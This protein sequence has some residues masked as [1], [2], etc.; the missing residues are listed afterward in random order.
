MRGPICILLAAI[1]VLAAGCGGGDDS[2]L[3]EQ[4]SGLPEYLPR[5]MD[6][7]IFYYAWYGTPE[8]DGEYRHWNHAVLEPDGS[9]TGRSYPGGDDI[10]S[11]FYPRTGCYSSNDPVTI[12]RHCFEIRLA[13][14]GVIC[15]SWWGRNSF[16]DKA[17]PGILDAAWQH[18]LRVDFHIEPF[19]GRTAAATREAI[20]YIIDE[21]G[22]HPAF[23]RTDRFGEK[24]MF[25][26]YD[27]YLIDADKW[28]TILTPGG[29]NTIRG[30]EYDALVIGLLVEEDHLDFILDSGFDGC[31]TYFAID[32]FTWGSTTT[33]WQDIAGW[34]LDNETLFIP[35][36]G[37]GYDDTRIRPWNDVNRRDRDRGEY[38]YAMFVETHRI[39]PPF[40]GIT[41]F[42]E[43]H[44][45]TQIESAGAM[46][47]EG[48]KYLDYSPVEHD[49]YLHK[50]RSLFSNYKYTFSH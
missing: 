10:G 45:G 2:K 31:Y 19:E 23:Y 24:P 15:V 28:K 30:T 18:G 33:N 49:F 7:H 46:S 4:I 5:S 8:F 13:G 50:T 29:A 21:Y 6:F 40:I 22:D 42:N 1:L 48:Y 9:E 37:P 12:A 14:A 32:G 39:Q 34:A 38:Y 41:S 27:S 26:V 3:D 20:A 35:C 11:N 47:I 16:S 43:W 25:Y 36:I 44:E 17:V